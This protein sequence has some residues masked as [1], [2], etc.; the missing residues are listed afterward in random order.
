MFVLKGQQVLQ[1]VFDQLNIERPAREVSTGDHAF[2]C[3]LQLTYVRPD[4]LSNKKRRIR[5]QRNMALLRLL[6]QNRD[7]GLQVWRIHRHR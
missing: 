3:P 4:P 5:C 6:H 1:A 2:K 7:P